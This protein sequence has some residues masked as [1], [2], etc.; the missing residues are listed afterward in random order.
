MRHLILGIAAVLFL[1]SCERDIPVVD[2]AAL[3]NRNV[4]IRLFKYFDNQV[5][6]TSKVYMI[7][8]DVIKLDHAYLT[9][10]GAE[11][12]SANEEDT[13][14]TESDLSMVDMLVTDQVKLAYLPKG[15]YNGQINYS[16]GLD[17]ARSFTPPANLEMSN[18]LSKGDVWNGDVLGHSYFQLEGRVF[19]A[20]DTTFNTP[21]NTF[22]WRLA[23][24]DMAL[25]REEKRNFNISENGDVVFV[26]N[27][28]LDKLFVGLS[29]SAM[30]EINSDAGNS[31]DY[32]LAQV[33]RDNLQ[34]EFVFKL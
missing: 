9:L 24:P 26:L 1:A 2:P 17:S 23:T 20:A 13:I 10:S 15:S 4:H 28:D 30:P 8:G 19:D 5:L 25:A 12:I 3:D 21:K 18:P 29:P 22:T 6:D 14:R 16:I 7:N 11:F 27:F 31:A 34:S 32:F 33:L